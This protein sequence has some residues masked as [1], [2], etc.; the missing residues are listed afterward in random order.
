MASST[1]PPSVEQ[2]SNL[3]LSDTFYTWFNVS[4]DI[5]NKINPIEVYSISADA[6][7]YTTVGADG[8][9]ID[10]LGQ[11]NYRIGYIMPSN[12]TGGHT[13]HQDINFAGGVSGPIVN[14]LNG[15]TGETVAVTTISGRAITSTVAG[16]ANIQAAVFEINGIS[17]STGGGLTLDLSGIASTGDLGTVL[18][19]T[20][21]TGT[22][23]HQTQLFTGKPEA[24][25]LGLRVKGAT[26]DSGVV[27]GGETVDPDYRLRV[28]GTTGA[29]G[30]ISAV[31]NE[32][33][34]PTVMLRNSGS[35]NGE[36]KLTLMSGDAGGAGT[37][38]LK[39]G[40][41]F[42]AGQKNLAIGI[43]S[44]G[45][46]I[47]DRLYDSSGAPG[48]VGQVLTSTGAGI[49]WSA[50]SAASVTH[51]TSTSQIGV[52]VAETAASNVGGF[53]LTDKEGTA[54]RFT[55]TG[56][57]T[58]P[59][60]VSAWNGRLVMIYM[61]I[62][63]SDDSGDEYPRLDIYHNNSGSGSAPTFGNQ[64][65]MF[66]QRGDG[67]GTAYGVTQYCI[68]Y[69]QSAGGSIWWKY[70]SDGDSNNAYLAMVG[71]SVVLI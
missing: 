34:G 47:V 46:Q 61:S 28:L 70:I 30:A 21:G 31:G 62:L 41:G 13:F 25:Q 26:W 4:N 2:V 9:T 55:D 59:G 7:D 29:S 42:T 3:V 8:I 15:V 48:T 24:D 18:T 38:E 66:V 14:T 51:I 63:G 52:A 36:D 58:V 64:K 37:I 57:T 6:R 60:S 5:V 35:I 39:T 1:N 22:F 16:V 19:A 20:G 17:A 33:F 43:S 65:N 54:L 67:V 50:S 56:L 40:T 44:Q 45:V 12:I 11:G 71:Y 53:D 68:P 69:V 10:D 23:S 27:M 32:D 49:S